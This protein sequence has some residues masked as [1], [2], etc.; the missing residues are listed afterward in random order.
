MEIHISP[1]YLLAYTYF[2]WVPLQENVTQQFHIILFTL[3]EKYYT[4]I[5]SDWHR[6]IIF[7]KP[8]I[9]SDKTQEMRKVELYIF[10]EFLKM[11][12]EGKVSD[13][14]NKYVNS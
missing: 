6:G 1:D 8:G 12:L 4:C 13:T 9:V 3:N 14:T 11:S 2:K 10:P 5:V 7:Q